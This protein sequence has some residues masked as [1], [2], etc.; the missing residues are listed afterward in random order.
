M[1]KICIAAAF[2]D[3]GLWSADTVDYIAPAMLLARNYLLEN[4]RASM[5]DE[6]C[7]MIEMHHK[8]LPYNDARYPLVETFRKADLVDV[9]L[10]LVRCGLSSLYV[11]AVRRAFPNAGFHKRLVA[12][13]SAWFVRNPLNP[14]PFMRW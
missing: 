3:L 8:V 1:E 5:V 14:V 2:H 4:Q 6:V 7:L 11:E 12:L 9:S 13:A 10:G